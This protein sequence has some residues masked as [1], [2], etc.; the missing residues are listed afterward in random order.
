MY[1]AKSTPAPPSTMSFP[2][3]PS[4]M[5]SPK[6]PLS[7]SLPPRPFRTSLPSLPRIMLFP[8]LPLST[9]LKFEPPISSMLVTVSVPQLPVFCAVVSARSRVTPPLRS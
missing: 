6:D 7:T 1:V 2:A 3:P 8:P 9:S 4:I 5:S